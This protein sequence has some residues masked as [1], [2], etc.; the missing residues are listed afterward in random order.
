M[1]AGVP[2]WR[3]LSPAV[4]GYSSDVRFTEMVSIC[5]R[6]VSLCTVERSIDTHPETTIRFPVLN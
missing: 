4:G 3:F 6:I 2:S 1:A 5:P